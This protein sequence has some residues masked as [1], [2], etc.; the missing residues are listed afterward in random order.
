ME[1]DRQGGPLET[2][3]TSVYLLLLLKKLPQTTKHFTRI[4]PQHYEI[5]IGAVSWETY[6]SFEPL[7][8]VKGESL[9]KKFLMQSNLFDLE[10]LV[11]TIVDGPSVGKKAD[12]KTS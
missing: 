10:Y 5:L 7:L 4:Y 3:S 11:R 8:L 9:L 1:T 6:L 2:V 12:K